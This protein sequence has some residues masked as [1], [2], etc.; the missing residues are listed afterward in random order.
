M[1]L[2]QMIFLLLVLSFTAILLLVGESFLKVALLASGAAL[3]A[4]FSSEIEWKTFERYR[5][6]LGW[7]VAFLAWLGISTLFTHNLPMSLHNIVAY[8][9]AAVVFVFFLG[10]K[11][12]FL[13]REWLLIG[14]GILCGWLTAISTFFLFFPKTARI[15]PGMNL[16]FSTFGH[17]HIAVIMVLILPAAWWVALIHGSWRRW[18]YFFLPLVATL[19]L[20]ISF[21]RV[22]TAVA[23]VETLAIV[24][25]YL[26]YRFQQTKSALKTKTTSQPL[27]RWRQM[28]T[29]KT[30]MVAAGA[31]ALIVMLGIKMGISIVTPT[32]Q[33]LCPAPIFKKELCKPLKDELRPKYWQASW[34][35][36]VANPWFGYGPGTTYLIVQRYRFNPTFLTTYT[37]NQFLQQF[38]ETGLI[39]GVLFL[40]LMG[41][42]WWRSLLTVTQP[43]PAASKDKK[44]GS[45]RMVKPWFTLEQMLFLG[46][47][48][49]YVVANFDIDWNFIAAYT[50][51]LVLLVAILRSSEQ[52]LNHDP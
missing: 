21:S 4:L 43:V 22:A 32:D 40:G 48:A 6:A 1:T 2:K 47:T 33:K 19:T 35:A 15:L 51:T 34:D 37:H 28:M 46:V 16:V 3:L 20:M 49:T 7:W 38:G 18:W 17:N 50:L 41:S 27:P 25:L 9:F 11:P 52:R 30:L 29:A 24:G 13:K 26:A 10:V 36:V 23:V 12:S 42:L 45:S 39:G 8:C 31:A 14:L 5:W 44:R